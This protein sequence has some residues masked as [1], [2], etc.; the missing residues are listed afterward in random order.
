MDRPDGR[1]LYG[2]LMTFICPHCE[3]GLEQTG[4]INRFAC[5]MCRKMYDVRIELRELDMK[6]DLDGDHRKPALPSP[7]PG[8]NTG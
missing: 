7:D 3:K 5:L 6:P 1:R 4:Q 2:L 8:V